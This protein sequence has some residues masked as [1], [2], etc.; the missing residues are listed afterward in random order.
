MLSSP[1]GVPPGYPRPGR[2]PP[3]QP[4]VGGVVRVGQP[5]AGLPTV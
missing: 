2:Q 4:D 5:S 1:G 3:R